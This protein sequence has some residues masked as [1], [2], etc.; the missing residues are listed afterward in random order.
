[1]VREIAPTRQV[2]DSRPARRH[3]RRGN[4]PARHVDQVST[5]FRLR[6]RRAGRDKQTEAAVSRTEG[7]TGL[8]VAGGKIDFSLATGRDDTTRTRES[9]GWVGEC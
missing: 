3:A 1:V 6:V 5:I 8:I 4:Q 7:P 2:I 9:E